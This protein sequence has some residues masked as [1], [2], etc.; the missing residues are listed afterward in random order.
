MI[1]SP[2]SGWRE[3]Q[4]HRGQSMRSPAIIPFNYSHAASWSA[5]YRKMPP[6]HAHAAGFN[7]TKR[8]DDGVIIDI[9]VTFGAHIVISTF[10]GENIWTLQA[11][12][13]HYIVGRTTV[14]V[15][16]SPIVHHDWPEGMGPDYGDYTKDQEM[17]KHMIEHLLKNYVP[18][19]PAGMGSI[20]EVIEPILRE[21]FC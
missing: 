18:R 9:P 17:A 6:P 21:R 20:A 19:G 8:Y 13:G 14:Q 7:D 2:N 4:H 15:V 11:S 16:D 3:F 12:G 5:R 1:S 10:G